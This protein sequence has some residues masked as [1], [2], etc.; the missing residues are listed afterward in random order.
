MPGMVI[1]VS[2]QFVRGLHP[3][4]VVRKLVLW[5]VCQDGKLV[6]KVWK[7]L[8]GSADHITHGSHC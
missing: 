7:Q 1:L 2:D 5:C 6:S 8:C 3:N 4:V